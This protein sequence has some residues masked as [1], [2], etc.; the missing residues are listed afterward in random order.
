MSDVTARLGLPLLASGQAQKEVTHNEA[1]TRLDR[2]TH[3]RVESRRE[4]TPPASP[5]AGAAWIVAADATGDWA[6]R[7]G[8]IAEWDGVW[9]YFQPPAGLLLWVA[10]ENVLLL[11]T[12]SGWS[13]DGLPVAGLSI[14]GRTLLASGTA[15][16]ND[17]DGGVTV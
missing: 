1:L 2:W 3:P 13:D 10:D 7:D 8:D 11:R 15:R 4:T 9:R 12:G 6:G 16:V 14:G 17:P 5:D